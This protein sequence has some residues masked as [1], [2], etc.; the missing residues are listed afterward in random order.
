MLEHLFLSDAKQKSLYYL[1]VKQDSCVDQFMAFT[2]VEWWYFGLFF[3][4]KSPC[5]VCQIKP[6]YLVEW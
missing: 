4:E 5:I 3:K 1:S 2:T 6:I